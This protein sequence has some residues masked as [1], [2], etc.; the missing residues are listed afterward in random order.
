MRRDGCTPKCVAVVCVRPNCD[1]VCV[2]VCVCVPVVTVC[3]RVFV[4]VC[5]LPVC[6]CVFVCVPVHP[7][8][9]VCVV[10]CVRGPF[11]LW[12]LCKHI[13]KSL[14]TACTAG[15]HTHTV[16]TPH[17]QTHTHSANPHTQT[18]ARTPIRVEVLSKRTHSER[19]HKI[20][21]RTHSRDT[22]G[23][24]PQT[25]QMSPQ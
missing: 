16:Q 3:V 11:S 6:M 17:T 1:V 13:K 9:S 7:S 19:I 10:S 14:I 4:C 2:C 24:M 15:Q 21:G 12:P 23:L 8:D 25:A 18:H 22:I 20:V 5:V